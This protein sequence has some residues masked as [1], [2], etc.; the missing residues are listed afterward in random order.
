KRHQQEE[1]PLRKAAGPGNAPAEPDGGPTPLHPQ[2]PDAD[3]PNGASARTSASA[4][5]GRAPSQAEA[6]VA[7]AKQAEI[8][9]EPAPSR[10]PVQARPEVV[11]ADASPAGVGVPQRLDPP[12][13]IQ[14]S[15]AR[16]QEA[17][18]APPLA[19]QEYRVLF[20]IMAREI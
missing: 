11:R 15:I 2:Q 18:Q 12:N 14:Q 3:G 7:A 10:G 5:A 13:P 16:I 19:P 9:V 20:E 4:L 17:C 8:E 1:R 6:P